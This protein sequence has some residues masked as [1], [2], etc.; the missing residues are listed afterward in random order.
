M[1]V[2]RDMALLD[3]V[4]RQIEHL[5]YQWLGEYGLEG[6]RYLFRDDPISGR[7]LVQAHCY[8]EGS[9]EI[10]RHLAFR[11]YLIAHPLLASEY[12]RV[13]I[14]CQSRHPDNSHEYGDCKSE[15]IIRLEQDALAFYE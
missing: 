1:P 2:V 12:E 11:D 15:L 6:R 5:G 8:K 9:S 13:K 14:G 10:A 3:A 7:R 4:Q